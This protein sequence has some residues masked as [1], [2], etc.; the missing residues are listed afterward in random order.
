MNLGAADRP[1]KVPTSGGSMDVR[2]VTSTAT[3]VAAV[4]AGTVFF[5]LAVLGNEW[6]LRNEELAPEEPDWSEE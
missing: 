5:A 3:V 2:W 1:W 4:I 6:R